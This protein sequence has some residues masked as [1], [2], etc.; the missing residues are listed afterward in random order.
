ME[1]FF[2][3]LFNIRQKI[4]YNTLEKEYGQVKPY[5]KCK[6]CS[7]LAKPAKKSI[8]LQNLCKTH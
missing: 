5:K 8:R 7:F 6:N 3:K 2:I 4:C 1:D